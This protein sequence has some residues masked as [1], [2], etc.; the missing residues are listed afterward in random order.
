MTK[1]KIFF[2]LSLAFIGGVFSASFYYPDILDNFYLLISVLSAI[3]IIA[4]FYKKPAM[5]A[6]FFILFFTFGIYLT[7][8]RL[9]V[10]KNPPAGGKEDSF[11]GEVMVISEPEIKGR[12]QRMVATPEAQPQR[13]S[14]W[15]MQITTG[16]F[17]EY[18]YGDVLRVDCK[19]ELPKNF[20]DS[21]FDY[22]MYLA[23]DEIYY[24][25]NNPQ[26]DPPADGYRNEGNRFYTAILRVKNK[27]NDNIMR[28]MPSPQSG[29]L[30]GLL[31][32]GSGLLSK[33][34]QNYFSLTGTTHIVAVSGYN[35]TIVAEYLMLLGIFIGL[36]R[37][38]AFWFA[39]IGIIIFVVL[40]GMPSSAVR[41]GVMG[42]LLIWAIK[43]G[44]LANAQNAI[45]FA[46]SVML[47]IN[48]LA[49]R[50]DVGFQLSF[51]A[52]LGIVYVYPVFQNLIIKWTDARSVPTILEI[53]L[54]T[55]SAQIF[56]LPILMT[57]FGKLSLISPLANVL[58]L[59]IIPLTMLIGFLA[60]IFSFI[61]PPI[62]Q[63]FA[64]LAF[65]P[66]KYE[67]MVIKFL[68]GLKYAS[69]DIQNFSWLAVVLWY[70]ILGGGIIL[71]KRKINNQN[72]SVIP[73]DPERAK[74]VEGE[75]RDLP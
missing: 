37:K 11:S 68:A 26:I 50:W 48:P 46:A 6:G 61:I 22:R 63:V 34:Y 3:I 69:V 52:T 72:K 51:L 33:D 14:L 44:R 16:I 8:K 32:G 25:C 40:T 38:Q 18:K 42:V 57:N 30:S 55:I 66:L 41:A 2:L 54:L 29:L 12:Q 64:W 75:S 70:I 49:L 31:I 73:S 19:L 15:S 60:I 71:I 53:L 59:P 27:F 23:K 10:V 35:V 47:L 36:W 39:T 21:N 74:R 7:E 56:V 5:M 17:P 62:G 20:E 28:L 9:E 4:V 45:L 67:T 1:S 58:V 13:L 43:N 65:L 24:L